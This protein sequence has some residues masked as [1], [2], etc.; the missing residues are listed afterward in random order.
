MANTSVSLVDTDADIARAY[1]I[2]AAA[3]G[4]QTGD[5]IWIATHP[6]WDTPEGREKAIA[7]L[8]STLTDTTKNKNGDPNI[9]FLKADLDGSMVGFA[10]WRQ[11]SALEGHGEPPVTEEQRLKDM[12]A[13]YPD[14]E[15]ESR[16][17]YQLMASLQRQRTALAKQKAATDQPALYA[18]DIC[19]VDPAFQGK[20]VAKKLVQWGVDEAKRRG[21][22]ELITEGSSMGRW[23][24]QKFG[25]AQEGPEIVY[26]VDEEF[27]GRKR[28]SNIFMRTGGTRNGAADTG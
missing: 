21:D 13:K 6:G 26:E 18:L 23:V 8:K 24:Y 15:T 22:L 10:I 28:P 11:L 25:F 3:F 12:K 19:A 16:Y 9:V 1:D 27:R 20:G 7:G 17:T 2:C 14:N 4:A 5:G